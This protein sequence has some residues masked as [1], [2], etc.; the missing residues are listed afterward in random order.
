MTR[1]SI[2]TAMLAASAVTLGGGCSGDVEPPRGAS[3]PG[4]PSTY[5][6]DPGGRDSAPGTQRRPWRTLSRA[7]PAL[8]PG[9][10]LLVRPGTYGARGTVTEVESGGVPG[11]PVTI[12]GVSGQARPRLLGH[13]E[14]SADHVRL[15]RI[16]FEG[17][18]GPVKP[19][20]PDNPKGEQV[21]IAVEEADHVEISDS[22]V[23]G[24]RW[25][26]GIFLSEADHARVVRNCIADNGDRDPAAVRFQ[27]NQSH[28]IYWSSGSGLLANNLVTSNLARGV[29]LYEHP[30]DV[31]VAHN[32]IV[33]N[34]R[35]GIQFGAETENSTAVGNVVA[36][37][38]DVGVRT[39]S[40]SGSGNRATHNLGWGNRG[41]DFEADDDGLELSANTVADPR[42]AGPPED[43][44]P[45]A[46]SPMVDR[47]RGPPLL[48]TDL[49]GV[50]RPQGAGSDLG[51]YER[52]S[53]SP[54][55]SKPDCGPSGSGS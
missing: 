7:L 19:R 44:R 35:A 24:S 42:F 3:P 23:R 53:P 12:A 26:A 25:H 32:T 2:L 27:A 5:Y 48:R 46:G 15:S 40:L 6:L 11:A 31:T 41:G 49:V 18:T 4:A 55:R 34:G 17:P 29:Q 47:L 37:N 36:F 22:V 8:R 16:L 38:G 52:P 45:T 14:V 21:Q 1:P 9:D 30:H 10:R 43:L 51:A 33:G 50:T 20:T 28:G 13:V 39:A 54:S